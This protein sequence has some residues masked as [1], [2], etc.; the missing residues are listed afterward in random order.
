MNAHAPRQLSGT[1]IIHAGDS[2]ACGDETVKLS[3]RAN[4]FFWIKAV[5]HR[6]AVRLLIGSPASACPPSAFG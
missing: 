1:A 6:T 3:R 4:L 5:P 2:V